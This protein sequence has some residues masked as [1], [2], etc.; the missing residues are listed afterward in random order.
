M[1]EFSNVL[2]N[3]GII[4]NSK[5]NHTRFAFCDAAKVYS[6]CFDERGNLYK[7][8]NDIGNPS[9]AYDNVFS[10][11]KSGLNLA[12]TNATAFL[13]HSFPEDSECLECKILPIC[14]GGCVLKRVLEKHKTCS[15]VKY[16]IDGYINK[17]YLLSVGIDVADTGN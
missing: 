5:T 16:D 17:K 12:S 10:A 1:Q 4:G 9:R 8:W 6:Y 13:A 3:V 7:C 11:V 2:K 14:M 15:P